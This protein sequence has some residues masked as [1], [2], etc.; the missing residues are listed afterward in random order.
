MCYLVLRRLGSGEDIHTHDS[1]EELA[2]LIID[3]GGRIVSL[4][5]PKLTHVVLDKRDISRRLELMKRTSRSVP[6]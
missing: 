2:Q 4:D 5:E 3:N 1:F 6:I